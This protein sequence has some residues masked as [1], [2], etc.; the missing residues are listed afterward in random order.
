H[1]QARARL[2]DPSRQAAQGLIARQPISRR[3]LDADSHRERLA[4]LRGASV[5]LDAEASAAPLFQTRWCP[6]RCMSRLAK[7]VGDRLTRARIIAAAALVLLLALAAG[8][9]WW[10]ALSVSAAR[11]R[12]E[13]SH[14]V[15]R[16]TD[17]VLAELLNAETGQRGFLLT[18]RE[19]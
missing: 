7:M 14:L 17:R 9:G 19:D 8:F 6:S 16:A 18:G 10:F 12:V 5:V 13:H 15:A 2:S 11:E 4:P 3:S 1:R